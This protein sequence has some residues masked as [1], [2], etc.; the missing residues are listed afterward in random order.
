MLFRPSFT[1]FRVLRNQQCG[2]LLIGLG[3][4]PV[5]YGDLRLG[6]LEVLELSKLCYSVVLS[7]GDRDVG[8]AYITE[9]GISSTL[10]KP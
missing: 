10:G 1:I 6:K 8:G 5:A 3:V 2:V 7:L 9:G 4:V